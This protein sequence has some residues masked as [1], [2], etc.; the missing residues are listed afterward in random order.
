MKL[1]EPFYVVSIKQ[2]FVRLIHLIV[3]QQTT[4]SLDPEGAATPLEAPKCL[5]GQPGTPLKPQVRPS[6]QYRGFCLF[7]SFGEHLELPPQEKRLSG[8]NLFATAGLH[9]LLV[10]ILRSKV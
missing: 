7:L 10:T 6:G 1:K 2:S 5:D 3:Q 4:Q 8:I 9:I